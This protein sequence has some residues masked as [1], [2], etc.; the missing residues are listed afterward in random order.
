MLD[1]LRAA[2]AYAIKKEDRR[3]YFVGAF[4]IR[5]D[6]TLVKA[7]NSPTAERNPKVHAESKL[8]RKLG[9]GAPV[10][11]VSRYS[12]NTGG[13]AMAKPCPHCESLLR[14][15]R[16]QQVIYSTGHDTFEKMSL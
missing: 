13:L 2:A 14:S 11:F 8:I 4:G 12:W 3:T 6:G 7:T 16:V 9:Y 1:F 5:A 10:V 15:Y